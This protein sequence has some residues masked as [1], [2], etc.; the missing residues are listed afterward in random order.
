MEGRE[1]S[2][3]TSSFDGGVCDGVLTV[4]GAASMGAGPAAGNGGGRR[5]RE[6]QGLDARG[7]GP[8]SAV[9]CRSCGGV[10]GLA[11]GTA[12]SS[13]VKK[14][15]AGVAAVLVMVATLAV[16]RPAPAFAVNTYLGDI[17]LRYSK[18][19]TEAACDRSTIDAASAPCFRGAYV[20][21]RTLAQL[22]T[23]SVGWLEVK[24][25]NPTNTGTPSDNWCVQT[26]SAS[27]QNVA[28]SP[29]DVGSGQFRDSSGVGSPTNCTPLT[30]CTLYPYKVL[31]GFSSLAAGVIGFELE[32]VAA[33]YP[34]RWLWD[35]NL[36][37][38]IP[39]MRVCVK[40]GGITSTTP[41]ECSAYRQGDLEETSSNTAITSP[42]VPAGS[43]P[44]T[45]S[46]DE[47]ADTECGAWWH[48]PCHLRR[49]FIPTSIGD[50][51][52]SLRSSIYDS[53]PFG[54]IAWGIDMVLDGMKSL[55]YSVQVAG[56][57]PPCDWGP[58]LN[59]GATPVGLPL[60][61]FLCDSPTQ[62]GGLAGMREWT[63]PLSTMV[64][65][66]GGVMLIMRLFS[67][68]V[69]SGNPVQLKLFD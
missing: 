35:N 20:Q 30:T 44:D 14:P 18:G 51:F 27:N 6:S 17:K 54:P 66:F 39:H 61:E 68:V 24:G 59:I 57:R 10:G 2:Y 65:L 9:C 69:G 33:R 67:W 5:C 41:L 29:S 58:T 31:L 46:G 23:S 60:G 4:P 37:S 63:K 21:V 13:R 7:R 11:L 43:E 45:G 48:L 28:C 52:D 64:F 38:V 42:D 3:G 50:S 15:G 32:G 22:P 25:L 53:F 26:I 56:D 47:D 36:G 19:L 62:D 55:R 12:F 40:P 8:D 16:F 49:L 34:A 1:N